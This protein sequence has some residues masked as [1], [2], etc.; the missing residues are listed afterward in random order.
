MEAF[1]SL[2]WPPYNK[3]LSYGKQVHS[4]VLNSSYVDM[5]VNQLIIEEAKLILFL[6]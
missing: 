6:Q 2:Q 5:G 4:Q 1:W 3:Y